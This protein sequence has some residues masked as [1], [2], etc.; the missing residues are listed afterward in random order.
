MKIVKSK[1]NVKLY[2]N[3]VE[4]SFN[5]MEHFIHYYDASA[6]PQEKL[7]NKH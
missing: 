7:R 1:K 2:L 3:S 6:V 4:F 5:F